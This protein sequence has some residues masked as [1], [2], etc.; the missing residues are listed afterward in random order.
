MTTPPF[1]T[2]TLAERP[3]LIDTINSLQQRSWPRFML[4]D[5][6]ALRLW[7]YVETV[8]A[9]FQFVLHDAAGNAVAYGNTVPFVWEGTMADLPTGW[10]DVLERAT[11]D[12]QARRQPNTLSALAAV[13]DPE[14]RGAGVSAEV[15]R[16]MRRIAAAHNLEALVAPVRPSL[17]SNY[18]LTPIEQYVTWTNA[19]GLFFDPWIRV[20]ARLGARM[21]GLAPTSMIITGTVSEWEQWS[22][23][24][25]PTS[26]AYVVPKALAPISVDRERDQATYIEP[27]VWMLHP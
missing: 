9:P 22:A 24:T 6:V 4:A 19:E 26:G 23:M 5:P 25:F 27:N 10:D 20:H 1:T 12:Y 18:P 8:F 17:K 14:L 7:N 13:V 11:T 2:T 16:A 3:E 21:I 15:L